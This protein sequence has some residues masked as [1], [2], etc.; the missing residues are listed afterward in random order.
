[1]EPNISDGP[2]FYFTCTESGVI[3][4][5]NQ[6]MCTHLAYSREE[7]LTNKTDL[8]FS[9]GTRIFLQTHLYPLLQL[10]GYADEILLTIQSKTKEQLSVLFNIQRRT[11]TQASFVFFGIRIRQRK[12]YEDMLLS[13]KKA[14][15]SALDNNDQ[16]K[17]AKDELQKKMEQLDQQLSI[18]SQQNDEL[19][20]INKVITHD[21]QEPL[22]KL[23][24]FAN[25]LSEEKDI[26]KAE[27]VT[28]RMM[29]AARKMA[30]LVLGLQEYVWVTE[31]APG[32]ERLIVAD[33]IAVAEKRLMDENPANPLK[34]TLEAFPDIEGSQTQLDLLF[35]HLFA[36]VSRF[37]K[38]G[39]DASATL[40]AKL[41]QLNKFRNT[42]GKYQYGDFIRFQLQDKGMGFN[43]EYKDQVFRLFQ[44]LHANSGLGIGL[45][46]CKKIVENHHGSIS[47]DSV[48][49]EG[50]LVTF[51]L[52]LRQE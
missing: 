26:M 37:S 30:Q 19:K 6:T 28:D 23:M 48:P 16:L 17:D 7:L 40:S 15:E 3:T 10:Q 18:V 13:G 31:A 21:L 12:D 25:L 27:K 49:G 2:C 24:L 20:Q 34:L 45:S 8:F 29:R 33:S 47:I 36:N 5:I 38:P 11:A 4:G 42:A 43:P 22:R 14:A 41:L 50:T 32:R 35:Y 44:P 52:P 9:V 51:T 39:T 46:L 1:M